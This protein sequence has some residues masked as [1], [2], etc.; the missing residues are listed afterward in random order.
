M[1][2][3]LFFS[4]FLEYIHTYL[5]VCV[6]RSRFTANLAFLSLSRKIQWNLIK[7][8]V[9]VFELSMHNCDKMST[10]RLQQRVLQNWPLPHNIDFPL[11][12]HQ[13]RVQKPR[14]NALL[15]FFDRGLKHMTVKYSNFLIREYF[16]YLLR[17][18]DI[19]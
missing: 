15:A 19:F 12:S 1:I 8:R 9:N 10:Y 7:L 11:L 16:M 6:H 2:F 4:L 17:G 13:Q 5:Y 14:L 3:F 18:A